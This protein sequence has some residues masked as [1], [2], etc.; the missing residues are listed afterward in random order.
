MPT[1]NHV[2][3]P[4]IK[5]FKLWEFKSAWVLSDKIKRKARISG[6]SGSIDVADYWLAI[7]SM[8]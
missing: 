7:Y 8:L 6:S 4:S 1:L 5:A 3:L 2:Y